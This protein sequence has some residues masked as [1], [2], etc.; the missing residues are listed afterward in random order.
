MSSLRE[1]LM[2]LLS[3]PDAGLSVDG[4]ADQE[5]SI[6]SSN[7]PEAPGTSTATFTNH[8]HGSHT[9]DV[10]LID[11]QHATGGA[12]RDD[13]ALR[14]R[15]AQVEAEN[16]R[17]RFERIRDRAESF[18]ASQQTA[19]KLFDPQR[20]SVIALYTQLASDDEVRGS[21]RAADGTEITRVQL[22]A[23]YFAA[24]T[25]RKELTAELLDPEVH[26]V[27]AERRRT[28]RRGEDDEPEPERLAQLLGQTSIGR[29]ILKDAAFAPNG[30][31]KN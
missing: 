5:A 20:A 29:Q 2:A 8:T 22:L 24:V 10:D 9:H 26:S 23:N 7:L 17:L 15:L 4:S 3:E 18:A 1:R 16:Q 27:L 13:S 30:A 19:L 28:P 21:I 14:E 11:G 6:V 12:V 25:S 31:S